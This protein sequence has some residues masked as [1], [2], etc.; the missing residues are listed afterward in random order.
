MTAAALMD[1]LEGSNLVTTGGVKVPHP[2]PGGHKHFRGPKI[3]IPKSL[4]DVAGAS[5]QGGISHGGAGDGAAVPDT[6]GASGVD[7]GVEPGNQGVVQGELDVEIA[8]N[9]RQE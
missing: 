1:S 5:R 9:L 7:V 8:G 3:S 2:I 4:P 6:A